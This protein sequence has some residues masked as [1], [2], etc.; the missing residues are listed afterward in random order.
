[1]SSFAQSHPDRRTG[2]RVLALTAVIVLQAL[3]AL[4]FLYDVG[5][6]LWR[7]GKLDVLHMWLEAIAALALAGGVV[8]LTIELRQVLHRLS[9]LD[10][11][12]R[13]ARG[14]MT[15]VIDTFFT[16]WGLT[17]SERD[18]ALLVLKGIDNEQ[19]AKIRGTAPGTVRAQC[20]AV[21]AKAGVDGRAQLFSVFMEELL[22]ETS[23]KQ[24]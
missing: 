18:V 17:P 12:M 15:E 2:R 23:G 14:E 20:T 4:F 5:I 16:E 1:M 9:R 22:S 19:I 6:D 13:A 21:Y 7:G 8:V 10:R 3:T 24:A 11:S